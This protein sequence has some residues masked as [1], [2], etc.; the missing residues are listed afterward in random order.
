MTENWVDSYLWMGTL[1]V[2]DSSRSNTNSSNN[3][4]SF[5]LL[6]SFIC[7]FHL[8]LWRL[9]RLS[10]LYKSLHASSSNWLYTVASISMGLKDKRLSVASHTS[11]WFPKHQNGVQESNWCL[12]HQ[13]WGFNHQNVTSAINVTLQAST[14]LHMLA[15]SW[16]EK[17]QYGV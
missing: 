7:C 5:D 16:R 13:V 4:C 3:C 12:K 9:S 8:H 2:I 1:V 15:S 10:V 14:W 11:T 17:H 6:R